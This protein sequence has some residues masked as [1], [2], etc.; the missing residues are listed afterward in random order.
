MGLLTMK[1][2]WY[3]CWHVHVFDSWTVQFPNTEYHRK[4][5]EMNMRVQGSDTVVGWYG[6]GEAMPG[7]AA[8]IHDFYAREC[9]PVPALCIMVNPEVLVT[10][11]ASD[12]MRAVQAYYGTSV[13]AGESSTVG[14]I[15]LPLR[16]E[17]MIFD[18]EFAA[19]MSKTTLGL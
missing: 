5:T 4:M 17:I 19:C 14:H 11:I 16:R 12:S 15:F 13:G 8:S 2:D 6:V 10:S 7:N 9:F 18:E 3:V 1:L